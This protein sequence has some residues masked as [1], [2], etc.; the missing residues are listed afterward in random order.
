MLRLALSAV[1]VAVLVAGIVLLR[2]RNR[3]GTLEP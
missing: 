3:Y 1:A 2:R